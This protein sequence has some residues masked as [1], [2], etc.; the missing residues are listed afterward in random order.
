MKSV[1]G[2]VTRYPSPFYE[3]TGGTTT[4]HLYAGNTLIGTI[5][6]G[7][8]PRIYHVHN[9]HLGSTNVV[10]NDIGYTTQVVAYYPF[11]NQRIEETY[12][13]TTESIQYVGTRHDAETDLNLMGARYADTRRGQFISQDP[14]FLDIGSSEFKQRYQRTLELHLMNPQALNSY[15]YAH[16]N[17]VTLKDP[18]GEIV[19]LLIAGWAAIEFG[20]ST[21]DAY[22]TYQTIND[23]NASGLEK[24]V[25]I[26]GFAVGLMAPGGG[27]GSAGRSIV[28]QSF[29]KVGTV[30]ENSAGKITGFYRSYAKVPYHGLDQTINRGVNP[31]LLLET[32]S[33][34]LVTLE[35]AGGNVL[36]LTNEA[37]VV[38]DKAG[39]VVTSY[40]KNEFLP[41]IRNILNKANKANN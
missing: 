27:Y 17:P 26:S 23:P 16:N 19:P 7:G 24:G 8:T 14:S 37:G 21:Y 35:Q 1:A 34:P 36:R 39:K 2:V 3:V 31:K 41:H 11:G 38:L 18:E 13:G 4:K 10:T 33:N 32:V 9:D 30:I 29:G 40:T 25:T 20:L 6:S 5:E 15:S 12:G 28:G 22:S